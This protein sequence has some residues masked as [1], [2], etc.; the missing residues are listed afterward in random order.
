MTER[1][2]RRVEIALGVIWLMDGALQFQPYMFSNAFFAGV[3]GMANMGLPGPLSRVDYDVSTM[4][5]AH[6]VWWNAC[7]AT[8]QVAIGAGLLYGRGRVAML[9]RSASILWGIGVWL[10][11]EGAGALFMGGTSLLTG[12][13]GAALLYPLVTVAIWPVQVSPVE[14]RGVRAGSVDGGGVRAGPTE[15]SPMPASSMKARAIELV[16]QAGWVLAWVGS[17]LLEL[18]AANHAAGVPGAQI[19][20]GAA[21]E[22]WVFA[23]LDRLVGH[24]VSGSGGLFAA[25]LGSAAVGIG[26]GVLWRRT[27]AVALV[28]G[29]V[30]ASF[31][32]L[33]GQNLGGVLTGQGTDPGT[34]PLL[35]LMAVIL[36]PAPARTWSPA[37]APDPD[38]ALA[39]SGPEDPEEM[40]P[41]RPPEPPGE[42]SRPYPR[43]ATTASA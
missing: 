15:G 1:R 3:L 27:R 32:G 35:I 33:V 43:P 38:P 39:S 22:P 20:N 5:A 36:W 7:F 11:G 28:S 8:F 31:V 10:V 19:A 42:H 30:V 29:I 2:R 4:L 40:P 41:A 14:G 24:G 9:A 17:A 26:I 18:Q 23:A 21:G 25:L 13:P 12:A 37:P 6:P 16:T 34:A